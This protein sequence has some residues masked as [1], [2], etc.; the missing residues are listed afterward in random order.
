MNRHFDDNENICQIWNKLFVT[1]VLDKGFV[2]RT[3][4]ELKSI[5]NKLLENGQNI[6]INRFTPNKPQH[7]KG[8]SPSLL[9]E[10]CKLEWP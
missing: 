6:G 9:I 8:R 5:R 2:F 1:Y 10:K 7:L 3:Y 4:K